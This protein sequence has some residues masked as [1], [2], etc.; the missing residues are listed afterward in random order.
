MLHFGGQRNRMVILSLTHL[1]KEN[2][3][4]TYKV[5]PGEANSKETT[6]SFSESYG[7]H[8]AQIA[9]IPRKVIVRAQEILEDLKEI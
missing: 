5:I 3:I 7:I 8:V 4:F 2:I 6:N 9:G 1:Q